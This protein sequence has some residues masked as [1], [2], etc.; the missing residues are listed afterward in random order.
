MCHLLST[1]QAARLL[2]DPSYDLKW[3]EEE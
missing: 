1:P 3:E 2:Q